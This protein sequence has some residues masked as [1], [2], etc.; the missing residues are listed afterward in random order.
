MKSPREPDLELLAQAS[1]AATTSVKSAVYLMSGYRFKESL[2]NPM[3]CSGI[4]IL[5]ERNISGRLEF[6]PA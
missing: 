2:R 4:L 1:L 5:I 3:H 6:Q